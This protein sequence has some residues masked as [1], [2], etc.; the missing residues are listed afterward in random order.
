MLLS[1]STET[2]L[3]RKGSH[4]QKKK[5]NRKNNQRVINITGIILHTPVII[6]HQAILC[7]S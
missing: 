7:S 3:K 1:Q 5:K 2:V 4:P 6:L